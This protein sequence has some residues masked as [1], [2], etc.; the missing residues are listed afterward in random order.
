M[1][2]RVVQKSPLGEIEDFALDY[3]NPAAQRMVGLAERPGGTLLTCFPHATVA[4]ILGYYRR[5]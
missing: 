3:L 4:G 5:V 1:V 2:K